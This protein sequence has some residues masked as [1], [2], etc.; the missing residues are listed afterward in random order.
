MRNIL[1]IVAG[2]TTAGACFALFQILAGKNGGPGFSGWEIQILPW[3][4]GG[5]VWFSIKNAGQRKKKLMAPGIR[6]EAGL[7]EEGI[8]QYASMLAH[9]DKR[10]V[11]LYAELLG[12]EGP[13]A[14]SALPAL[15][16]LLNTGDYEAGE[17]ARVA[18]AKIEGK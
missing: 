13:R 14:K 1:A 8:R 7:T 2:A 11:A 9:G 15:R 12:A 4:C 17:K 10:I 18:I 16:E 5:I 6:S 3:V